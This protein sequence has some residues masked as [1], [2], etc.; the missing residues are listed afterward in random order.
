MQSA[1]KPSI[2]KNN[3]PGIILF[4]AG[5]IAGMLIIYFFKAD[6]GTS[7]HENN[8]DNVIKL[9]SQSDS[10]QLKFDNI[11]GLNKKYASFLTNKNLDSTQLQVLDSL[12]VLIT[13]S[14]IVFL[15]TLD[16]LQINGSSVYDRN[17]FGLLQRITNGYRSALE[18]SDAINAIR[19]AFN[20]GNT[21]YSFDQN[22][23]NNMQNELK[24]KQTQIVGLS[25]KLYINKNM[26][27]FDSSNNYNS[28]IKQQDSVINVSLQAQKKKNENLISYDKKLKIENDILSN[29]VK[30]L[31]SSSNTQNQII[32]TS[33]ISKQ[34]LD[35][36]LNLAKADCYLIRAD[37]SQIISN[38]KQRRDLLENA[39]QILNTLSQSNNISIK[40]AAQS[41]LSELK[42]IASNNHD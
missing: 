9:S 21:N 14:Q 38:S 23:L 40:Q 27:K 19:N 32:T 24:D 39:L 18:Q 8:Y 41:K 3:W 6:S 1:Y 12:N 2:K 26:K 17:S 22:M 31:S 34:D 25:S 4:I 10:L 11:L 15:E 37:A 20:I 35:A 13:H 33:M 7:T 29:Q 42:T 5:L 30:S 16:N 28:I 36:Q